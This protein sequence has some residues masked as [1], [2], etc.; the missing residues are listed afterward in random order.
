MVWGAEGTKQ[1]LGRK[2][3]RAALAIGKETTV[4]Q[5]NTGL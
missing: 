5:T 3:F 1:N 2:A 4:V